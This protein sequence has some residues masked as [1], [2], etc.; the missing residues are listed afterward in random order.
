MQT[1]ISNRSS[2]FERIVLSKVDYQKS[3]INSK[4]ISLNGE[5]YDVKSVSGIGDKVE[6]LVIH[7]KKEGEI[8]ERIQKAITDKSSRSARTPQQILQLLTLVYI[9]PVIDFNFLILQVPQN[10]FLVPGN[11]FF[12]Y[13][14]EVTSPPP[15]KA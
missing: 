8:I 2:G 9:A 10:K 5:M 15:E 11:F 14:S 1:K 7:D 6:L 13:R 4:E 12:S 3:K